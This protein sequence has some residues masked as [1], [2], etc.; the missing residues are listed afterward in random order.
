M[1][2]AETLDVTPQSK[3]PLTPE[4]DSTGR[5]KRLECGVLVVAG[6]IVVGLLVVAAIPGGI[7]A[8]PSF[9]ETTAQVIPV[10]I[11]ALAVEQVWRPGWSFML[12]LLVVAILVAGEFAAMV[13]TAYDVQENGHTGYLVASSRPLTDMLEYFAVVGLGVGLI[14]VLWSTVF[15]LDMNAASGCEK[16]PGASKHPPGS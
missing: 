2:A 8:Q 16:R 14:A 5:R 12:L 7:P 15:R 6:L 13:G 3:A 11:L 9:Y 1:T 4:P 10:L